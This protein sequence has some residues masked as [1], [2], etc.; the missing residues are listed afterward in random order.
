MNKAYRSYHK[1]EI[2]A[3]K[4]SRH[5]TGYPIVFGERSLLL[6]DW[7]HGQVYEQIEPGAVTDELLR[8]SDIVCCINHDQGQIIGR[9]QLGKGSLSLSIDKHGV[10]MDIEAP[11][12]VYGDIVCESCARGDLSGMSFGFWIDQDSDISYTREDGE[13]GEPVY[14]RHVNKIRGIFDVSIVTH[15]AYPTTEVQARSRDIISDL[16]R[17]FPPQRRSEQMKKD[18]D[19]IGAFIT[20]H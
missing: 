16:E 2:R 14:I 11:R 15:P 9:S 8:Q 13:D 5:L 3:D 1:G 19:E 12:T 20:G 4:E 7:D 6:P 18:Y 17:A 10:A